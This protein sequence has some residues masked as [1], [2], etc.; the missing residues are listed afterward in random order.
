MGWGA[1]VAAWPA[2]ALVGSHE[3]LMKVIRGSRTARDRTSDSADNPDPLGEQ[4]AEMFADQ[5]AADAFL[6]SAQSARS[7]MW[8]SC[9]RSGCGTT[10]LQEL[11]GGRKI[12]LHEQL[13]EEASSQA[14]AQG[15]NCSA[16]IPA[17]LLAGQHVSVT[18]RAAP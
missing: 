15:A 7:S 4:A 14:D 6:Q 5:L 2:V 9:G 3:L 11:H 12:P 13:R 18:V 1:A 17:V 8:A 16:H 10:W